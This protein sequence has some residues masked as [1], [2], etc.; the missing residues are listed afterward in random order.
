MPAESTTL[1]IGAGALGALL[2]ATG[3]YGPGSWLAATVLGV[4]LWVG[5]R[6]K[7]WRCEG[8]D[9]RVQTTGEQA[10]RER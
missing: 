7:K 2:G 10:E 3:L 5:R 1:A 4:A 9:E 8:I 6:G